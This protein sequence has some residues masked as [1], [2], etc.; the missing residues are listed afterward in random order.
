MSFLFSLTENG[1]GIDIEWTK[2]VEGQATE[3]GGMNFGIEGFNLG[4]SLE[5]YQNVNL[6]FT[7]HID[8]KYDLE[9]KEYEENI[10]QFDII[11][12]EQ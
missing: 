10:Y 5:A 7:A 6:T 8:Y 12:N 1:I 4:G 3:L 11:K 9:N 2:V